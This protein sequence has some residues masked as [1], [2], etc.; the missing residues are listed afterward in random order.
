MTAYIIATYD[1]T[2][3]EGFA[4]YGPS[5]GPTFAGTGVEV[6][7]VD[8]ASTPLEGDAPKTT[9]VLKFPDAAAARAWYDSP[10][11]GAIKHLRTDNSKGRM[12]LVEGFVPPA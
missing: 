11:Y 2:N 10:Q 1:V 9:V 6:L 3:P 5:V 8:P 4:A 12:V 7:A